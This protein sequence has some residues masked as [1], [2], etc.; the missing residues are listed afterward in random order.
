M[1]RRIQRSNFPISDQKQKY[2]VNEKRRGIIRI[3][4]WN[5]KHK[6]IFLRIKFFSKRN[7]IFLNTCSL[8]CRRRNIVRILIIVFFIYLLPSFEFHIS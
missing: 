5:M 2:F 1:G 7:E 6:H 8:M 4:S 3:D